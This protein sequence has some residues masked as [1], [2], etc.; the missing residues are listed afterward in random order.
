MSEKS[1]VVSTQQKSKYHHGDLRETLISS[2]EQLV[3][4]KG[5]E[6]FSLADACRLA[7]VS[8]AAPY[9]HFQDKD[10]ILAIITARAF[11][12]MAERSLQKASKYDHGTTERIVAMGQAYVSFAVEQ[13]ALFRL[14]FGQNPSIKNSPNVEENGRSCF[15]QLIEQITIY[16]EK[17]KITADALEIGI[18]LWTFVHGAASLLIDEDYIKVAPEVDINHIHQ[19]IEKSAPMLLGTHIINIHD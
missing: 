6:N 19:M 10:E 17:N 3:I 9:R 11:D 8:T 12:E 5:A 2:V 1:D 14:M 7:G 18:M 15:A 4:E 16:C 13:Q